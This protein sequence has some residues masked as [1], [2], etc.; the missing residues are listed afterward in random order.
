MSRKTFNDLTTTEAIGV[1][2]EIIKVSESEDEIRERLSAEGFDGNKAD[3][4]FVSY[5]EGKHDASVDV[6][7]PRKEIIQIY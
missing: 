7:G 4:S 3:V 1:I 5:E 6:D 2:K